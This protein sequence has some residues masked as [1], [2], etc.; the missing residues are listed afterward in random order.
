MIVAGAIIGA[1]IFM[2]SSE[3][4]KFCQTSSQLLLVW[5]VGGVIAFLGGLCFAELG[6]CSPNRAARSST[7]NT[8]SPPGS[9]FFSAGRC[10]APSRR[11]RSPPFRPPA[12]V[13]SGRSSRCRTGATPA[14]AR[15]HLASDRGQHSRHQAGQLGPEHLHRPQDR[16]PG[17]PDRCRDLRFQRNDRRAR[18]L[19]ASL[20]RRRRPQGPERPRPGPDARPV[21]LRRL[22]EPEF[23]RR[24]SEKAGPDDPPGDHLRRRPG[25]RRLYPLQRRLC[26]GASARAIAGSTKLASDA[27][28]AMAGPWGGRFISAA[29]IV[30]TFGITNVFILTGARVYQVMAEKRMFIPAA[31]RVHPPVRDAAHRHP[32]PGGLGL[33]PAPVQHLRPAAPVRHVRRLDLLRPHGPG[34]DR[35]PEEDARTLERPYRTWG[36]PADAG[37]LFGH[38]A[39]PSSSTCS[40]PLR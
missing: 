4:A 5:V 25:G 37:A 24:R 3:S 40:S 14:A 15:H 12:P 34:P 2:N 17:R 13:S 26:P 9:G 20:S 8:R 38:F 22:A 23:R 28:E 29:I 35:P 11:G 7:S 39:A 33:G 32:F 21:F 6:A 31:A 19:G 18:D 36:Y 30:S 27:L 10:S 16:R 1:G